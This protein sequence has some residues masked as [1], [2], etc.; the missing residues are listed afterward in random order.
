VDISDSA[1]DW[2]KIAVARS[3]GD[4]LLFRAWIWSPECELLAK[5]AQ[6]PK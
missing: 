4:I 1:A 6:E 3:E 2:A 5:F